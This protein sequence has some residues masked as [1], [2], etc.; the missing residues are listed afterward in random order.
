MDRPLAAF[1]AGLLA[2]GVMLGAFGAHGL[3]DILD[4]YS[5]AVY[6]KAVF[7]HFVH[8]LGALLVALLP[9]LGGITRRTARVIGALLLV[10][11]LIFSGSLYLIAVTGVTKLGMITPLGGTAFIVAWCML[12]YQ[13][14]VPPKTS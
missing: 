7:Y 8:A 9:A 5:T 11:V 10:G 4:T 14:A 13:L 12:A 1:A 3:K 6:E 2:A